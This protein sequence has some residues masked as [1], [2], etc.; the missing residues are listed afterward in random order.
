MVEGISYAFIS[1]VVSSNGC[2]ETGHSLDWTSL[3][4]DINQRW[5]QFAMLPAHLLLVSLSSRVPC[6]PRDSTQLAMILMRTVTR[7]ARHS[8]LLKNRRREQSSMLWRNGMLRLAISLERWRPFGVLLLWELTMLLTEYAH[9]HPLSCCL[10]NTVQ[11]LI[12]YVLY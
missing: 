8:I 7:L 5:H 1:V 11:A 2:I 4:T 6:S 3:A 10:T 12:P 9:P